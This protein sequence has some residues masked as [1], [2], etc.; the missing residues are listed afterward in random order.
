MT[1]VT[2]LADGA[3]MD[4]KLLN[5][6]KSYGD[7]WSKA[8]NLEFM[9]ET[10]SKNSAEKA[11]SFIQK[12]QFGETKILD[13]EDYYILMVCVQMPLHVNAVLAVSGFMKC[14]GDM[15]NLTDSGWAA[16]VQK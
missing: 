13:V 7:D 2:S 3:A 16:D 4:I 14:I 9:M 10:K 6:I 5:A 1:L 15:F 11:A 12:N 8:R